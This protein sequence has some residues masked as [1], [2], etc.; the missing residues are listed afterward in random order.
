MVVNKDWRSHPQR[1]QAVPK[2]LPKA[3]PKT[4][5]KAVQGTTAVWRRWLATGVGIAL[6]LLPG[7][8]CAR[9]VA[10]AE[11]VK[12]SLGALELSLSLEAL[13]IYADTGN[14]TGDLRFYA[15]FLD[16]ANRAELRR[17]LQQRFD[18]DPVIV[19][20]I[21]YAPLGERV[22]QGLG[23][24]VQTENR[25]NGFKALRAAA[26]LAAS[27]PEKLSVLNLIRYY[28]S[29][30]IRI[31]AEALLAL[32]QEF[33]AMVDYRDAAVR[34]IQQQM[35]AEIAAAPAG[36]FAQLPDLSRVG[37]SRVV[38][39][40]LKFSRDRQAPTGEGIARPFAVALYLPQGLAQP[41][42]V[43][44]ISHGLGSSPA[45]FIYLARHLASHGFVVVVP[46]H[47]GSDASRR[48]ALL[49][50]I[51]GSDVS[52]DE[53]IDRPLD[54]TATLDQ[55]EQLAQSDPTL[56]GRMDLQTV[57]AIGHSFGGYTV[58][59]LA[60]ADPNV[61]R[62]RQEC[63]NPRPTLNAAPV[64]QCLGDNLP[65]G[66]TLRDPRIKAVFAISPIISVV[67]GPESMSKIQIPT[68][69]MGGSEDFIASTV[70]EQIHPFVW[71][72]TPDKYL[73][74]SIPSNHNYADGTGG[75]RNPPAGS[76]DSF[77]AGPDPTLARTYVRE[78]SLAFMQRYLANRPESSRYLTAAYAQHIQQAPLQLQ[79]VQALTAQQLEQAYGRKPPISI[80]PTLPILHSGR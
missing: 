77:L 39:R 60:G 72:T 45:A 63:A 43:V 54:I 32:R 73:A 24:V 12:V 57:G 62:L 37:G 53:F 68:L 30:S 35:D 9:P 36:N 10:A 78:L 42:P 28:P 16:D 58:L 4:L 7:A 50:G 79:F 61:P 71:L 26:V 59:A 76:I 31:N 56:R 75:D 33:T 1:P 6:G 3:V 5:P 64:L 49:S 11:A 23:V 15:R 18:V 47:I 67:L 80:V 40:T 74:I 41:A 29:T 52:P 48:E 38:R 17:F 19:S 46:Q 44:V 55:L 65:F 34:A 69:L 51:V 27:D 8:W 70:Q 21:T 13:Q 22:L 20:Q 66:G 14:I 25:T 2:T